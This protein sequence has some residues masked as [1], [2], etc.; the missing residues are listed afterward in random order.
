MIERDVL[1]GD[2]VIIQHSDFEYV[3]NGKIMVIERLGDEEGMG[4]WSLKEIVINQFPASNRNEFG[5]D[6]DF[7][8]PSVTL[9]SHNSHFGPWRLSQSGRYRV[10]GLFLRSLRPKDVRLVD[11]DTLRHR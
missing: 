1:D 7:E 8:N 10:R 6:I 9:R 2:I 5:D 4:A 3:E 11:S